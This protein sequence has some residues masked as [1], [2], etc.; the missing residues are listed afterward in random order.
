MAKYHATKADERF[1]LGACLLESLRGDA[2]IVAQD[3]GHEVLKSADAITMI[4]DAVRKMIFPLQ[5]QEAKEL[6]RVGA[7]VGGV[8]A[9]QAGE[10]MN[11]YV[12]RRKGWYRK[13]KELDKTVEI[14]DTILGDLLLDNSGLDRKERLMVLTAVGQTPSFEAMEKALVTQHGKLHYRRNGPAA[15]KGAKSSG[16]G[17][18]R[19][20][21]HLPEDLFGSYDAG[22]SFWDPEADKKELVPDEHDYTAF[23]ADSGRCNSRE[24][25][26]GCS[27]SL[28]FGAGLQFG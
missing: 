22:E 11:S 28:P 17:K 10:S 16:K 26:A 14:S 2:Y 13:L 12:G 19:S 25:R 21:P 7:S 8:M 9:R 4:A 3:L 20:Q 23:V 18:V 27:G 15:Y 1:M 24:C 6:C 5:A